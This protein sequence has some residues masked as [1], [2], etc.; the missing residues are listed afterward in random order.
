MLS[1]ERPSRS[2]GRS[3]SKHPYSHICSILIGMFR[4]RK[5]DRFAIILTALSVTMQSHFARGTNNAVG[6]FTPYVAA[7]L[8]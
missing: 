6:G 2:E 3:Q 5:N 8:F 7:K 4:L 1:E